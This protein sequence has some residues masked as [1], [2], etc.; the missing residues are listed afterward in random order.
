MQTEKVIHIF[1]TTTL[2]VFLPN[3]LPNVMYYQMY[4]Y[5]ITTIFA[6]VNDMVPIANVSWLNGKNNGKN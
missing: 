3:V 2:V 1:Y 4:H 6:D 5:L